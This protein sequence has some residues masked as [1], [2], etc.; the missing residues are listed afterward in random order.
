MAKRSVDEFY[1]KAALQLTEIRQLQKTL[2]EAYQFKRLTEKK[3]EKEG[4]G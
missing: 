2:D 4:K 3:T 1:P